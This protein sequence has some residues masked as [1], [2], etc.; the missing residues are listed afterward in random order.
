MY[1]AAISIT[2]TLAIYGAV[3]STL[4]VVWG[5]ASEVRH[6]KTRVKAE[7]A[8]GLGARLDGQATPPLVKIRA[9]NESHHDVRWTHAWL[10]QGSCEKLLAV[11]FAL[12]E[13]LPKK[14]GAR[15]AEHVY[16]D[17]AAL[18]ESGS[19]CHYD[20]DRPVVAGITISTGQSFFTKPA[21]LALPT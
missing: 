16:I 19:D 9:I 17:A 14:V 15:D 20:F 18:R 7:M 13:P 2:T 3:V 5:I 6:R 8:L 1:V 11:Q 10:Q 4:A 12:G 21:V